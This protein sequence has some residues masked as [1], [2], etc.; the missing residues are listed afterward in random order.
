LVREKLQASI[1]ADSVSCE[2]HSN[3]VF[4]QERVVE[5][6]QPHL[7]MVML[8]RGIAYCARKPR[9]RTRRLQQGFSASFPQT[10]ISLTLQIIENFLKQLQNN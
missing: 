3:S 8:S 6:P 7:L 1:F 5:M 2:L 10:S 9:K 4:M